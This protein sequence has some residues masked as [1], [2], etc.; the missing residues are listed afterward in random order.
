MRD[1]DHYSR[2]LGIKSP[3]SVS[4]VELDEE[5]LTVKLFVRC[6]IAKRLRC[7]ECRKEC[8]RYDSRRRSWRH[9]DTM[10]FKTF[11]EAEVPRVSCPDHGIL[12]VRVPW[13]EDSSRYTVL[14]ES[15]VID[16]LLDMSISAVARH[17]RLSWTAVDGI[18][19]RAVDRG[20][21]R[22]SRVAPVHLSVDETSYQKRHEY[23]TVVS[24]QTSGAVLYVADDR[25]KESL[26]GYFASL[27]DSE[28]EGIRSVSMDMWGA[29]IS[30][31]KQYLA[32]AS[33]L[34]C[35]DKFHVAK[36]LGMGL[37]AVRKA[38]H[39]ELMAE[40]NDI[41]KRTR[42]RWLENPETMDPKHW[43]TFRQLR[44]SSLRT[45][46][47]YS[48]K[49]H[50]MSLWNYVSRTWARKAWQNWIDRATSS[51]LKQMVKVGYTV[52]D[53]LWGII[54]AIV[55][56]R[57]N[58]IAENMNGRIQRVKSRACGYRNRERFRRVIMFYLGKL[59]LHPRLQSA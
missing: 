26:A 54:N 16:L 32:R 57:D 31:V 6:D 44:D 40:G 22:R 7:P 59:D 28:R 5:A 9:L 46:I 1:T 41:L 13:A 48:I 4:F 25:S 27:T 11:I 37:D 45:A 21:D 15:H 51:G 56:K 10:Q 38:E 39:R 17:I 34:I 14:F 43:P 33:E 58:A 19:Q 24:D 8:P 36:Y 42:F 20:L 50:A 3:W 30:V 23:V 47:A 53:Y 55:L 2:L 49:E 18:M 12:T 52:S 35:F 29:Y